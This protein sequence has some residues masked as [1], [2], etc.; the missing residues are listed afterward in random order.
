LRSDLY[1]LLREEEVPAFTIGFVDRLENT[2]SP[3]A[4]DGDRDMAIKLLT[5]IGQ[6]SGGRAFFPKGVAP[7][8]ETIR[9]M[10]TGP[11]Q[12]I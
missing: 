8:D 11:H 5:E 7:V 6:R 12:P 1:R 2:Q 3:F 4:R 9:E 10:A